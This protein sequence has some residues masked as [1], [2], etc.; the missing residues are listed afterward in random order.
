MG[1]LNECARDVS[2]LLLD[3]GSNGDVGGPLVRLRF[4]KDIRMFRNSEHRVCFKKR[5]SL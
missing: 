1:I 5:L 4:L 2:D 3:Q